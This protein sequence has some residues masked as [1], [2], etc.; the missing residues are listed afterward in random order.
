MTWAYEL[1]KSGGTEHD[2]YSSAAAF[3]VS[4][5]VREFKIH[6]KRQKHIKLNEKTVS[7]LRDG[8]AKVFLI[9]RLLDSHYVCWNF[10]YVEAADDHVDNLLWNRESLNLIGCLSKSDS[11][12]E[13]AD[14][15]YDEIESSLRIYFVVFFLKYV[16]SFWV[17]INYRS[18]GQTREA[19]RW[20]RNVLPQ[21]RNFGQSLGNCRLSL[22]SLVFYCHRVRLVELKVNPIEMIPELSLQHINKNARTKRPP[23]NFDERPRRQ[24]FDLSI[25]IF[26]SEIF[27]V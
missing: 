16:Q 11:W 6:I 17:A 5:N 8:E 2:C 26:C 9:S 12:P 15:V 3:V 22:T 14:S 23:I 18:K 24:S 20:L 1:D 7:S 4:R 19:T 27:K 10:M 21:F 25:I 13:V